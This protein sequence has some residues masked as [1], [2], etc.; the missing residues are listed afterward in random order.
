V[1]WTNGLDTISMFQCGH[2]CGNGARCTF[3]TTPQS[4]SVA[5][6]LGEESFLFVGETARANLQKMAD[7]L[8]P[9]LK[10]S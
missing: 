1:R 6:A 3:P 10:R 7:S 5:T 4:A 8:K 2:P 9:S